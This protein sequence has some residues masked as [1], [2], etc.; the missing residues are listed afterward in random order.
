[1][2]IDL[3]EDALHIKLEGKERVWAAKKSVTL[4]AESITNVE[5]MTG[6]VNRS[7]LRGLRAPGTSMPTLF[8]A[9]SFY[10]K[11]GWEFWYLRV[12]RSGFLVITTN[13]KRYHVVRLSVD[14][15]VGT[16][17]REWFEDLMHE[18]KSRGK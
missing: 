18:R 12:R 13:L 17:V 15:K 3:S 1:M 2:K 8:Y 5:W 11:S 6:T 14:E 9:G 7:R 16:K 10:R 4:T